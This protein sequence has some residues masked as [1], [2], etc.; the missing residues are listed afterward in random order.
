MEWGPSVSA[1]M[2]MSFR[3]SWCLPARSVRWSAP[4]FPRVCC[5]G[6]PASSSVQAGLPPR[7]RRSWWFLVRCGSP[8]GCAR[9]LQSPIK[10]SNA[11]NSRISRL[12]CGRA[13]W[14]ADP[15]FRHKTASSAKLVMHLTPAVSGFPPR[16]SRFSAQREKVLAGAFRS[17]RFRAF[18]SFIQVIS[19]T[20][21][22]STNS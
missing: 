4:T 21:P 14:F 15:P 2:P 16:N 22:P 9:L 1:A 7:E 19:S 8:G 13:T 11:P 18:S 20:C 5:R 10:T 12:K 17:G 6:A 3:A